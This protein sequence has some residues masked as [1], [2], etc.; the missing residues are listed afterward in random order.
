VWQPERFDEMTV[1]SSPSAATRAHSGG[2]R[3][4]FLLGL[5]LGLVPV[6]LLV[7]FG[8]T[9]CPLL[10]PMYDYTCADPN[11]G[12]GGWFFVLAVGFYILDALAF[13]VCV[14]IRRV[15]PVAWGLL[16]M[17]ICAP[18]VGFASMATIMLLRHPVGQ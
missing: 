4:L 7:A 18:F 15:R 14:W 8:F 12:W 1:P 13:L 6:G 2:G 16:T 17:L 10:G 3:R 11:Q 9:Q 5:G